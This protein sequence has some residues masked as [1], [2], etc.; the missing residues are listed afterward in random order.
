MTEGMPSLRTPNIETRKHKKLTRGFLE[1]EFIFRVFDL[2]FS[3]RIL[4]NSISKKHF[5]RPIIIGRTHI[6]KM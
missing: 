2:Q 4:N 1:K 3:W 6:L 5:T